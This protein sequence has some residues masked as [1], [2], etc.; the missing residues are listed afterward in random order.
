M[1]P[2]LR[3]ELAAD[4]SYKVCIVTGSTNG[5]I[6]WHHNLIYAGKQV[7]ERFAILPIMQYIH[8]KADI[9]HV[10]AI[11]DWIMLNRATEDELF[12]YSKAVNLKEKRDRLNFR[13]HRVW[14]EGDYTFHNL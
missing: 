11:L 6:E 12:R 4:P 1:P 7:Q 5:K 9:E 14:K 13:F 10:K 8:D 3:A 2:S